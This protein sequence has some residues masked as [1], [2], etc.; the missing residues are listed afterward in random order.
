[1]ATNGKVVAD[2]V[3]P[4]GTQFADAL[5]KLKGLAR[6]AQTHPT[7]YRRIEAVAFTNGKY[8]AL[9]LMNPEVQEAVVDAEDAAKLYGGNLAVDYE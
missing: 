5:P 7:I 8:R 4:H 6:Y 1:M 2:I 9:D 3:D